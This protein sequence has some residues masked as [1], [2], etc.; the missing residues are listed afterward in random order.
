MPR[1]LHSLALFALALPAALADSAPNAEE[2]VEEGVG[3][4][5]EYQVKAELLRSFLRYSTFPEG[6]FANEKSPIVVLV[7]GDDPFGPLIK[8]A[9]AKKKFNGR[10]IQI[11]RLRRVPNR[12][13]AHLVFAH[14]LPEQ[15]QAALIAKLSARPLLFVSDTPGFVEAGGFINLYPDD[16]KIRF[17]INERCLKT[18]GVQLKADLLKL[19][20]IVE[21]A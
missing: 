7:L 13:D 2:L 16:G 3:E 11:R 15:E 6:S 5:E 18:R 9:F 12:I 21:E 4:S 19:A 1:L 10:S 20:R 14:E 8:A 17:E